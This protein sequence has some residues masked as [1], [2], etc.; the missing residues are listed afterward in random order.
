MLLSDNGKDLSLV[1]Y[2]SIKRLNKQLNCHNNLSID[3]KQHIKTLS[4]DTLSLTENFYQKNKTISNTHKKT[5]KVSGLSDP[6]LLELELTPSAKI[7]IKA[8]C[9]PFAAITYIDGVRVASW[10]VIVTFLR[11]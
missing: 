7:Y 2:N 4:N 8:I 9:S 5:N 10:R 1:K 6:R 11:D 3:A